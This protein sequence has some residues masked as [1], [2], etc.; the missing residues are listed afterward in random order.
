[1]GTTSALYLVGTT[2]ALYLVGTTSALYLVGTT[3]AFYLVG[4]TSALY[5][6][7]SLLMFLVVF[8][9]SSGIFSTVNDAITASFHILPNSKLVNS[10]IQCHIVS[11][12]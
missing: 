11:A 10:V 7:R 3:S 6:R 9:I 8:P 4:T 2:S 5:L 12:T 1:V